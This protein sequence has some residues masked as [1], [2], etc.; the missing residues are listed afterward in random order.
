MDEGLWIQLVCQGPGNPQISVRIV[1]SSA[2]GLLPSIQTIPI[3]E[4]VSPIVS[5]GSMG[6]PLDQILPIA[7]EAVNCH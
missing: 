5:L 7:E 1:P 2:L 6:S 3:C 4:R